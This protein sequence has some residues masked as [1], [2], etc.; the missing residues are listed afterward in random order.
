MG[1]NCPEDAKGT[2][3]LPP[4]VSG[5]SH[6]SSSTKPLRADHEKQFANAVVPPATTLPGATAAARK[7]PLPFTRTR[8]QRLTTPAALDG[9]TGSTATPLRT[10][11]MRRAV[12]CLRIHEEDSS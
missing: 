11:S 5:V 3:P 2:A 10:D 7:S 8:S 9:G 4:A 6:A 1:R 12:S